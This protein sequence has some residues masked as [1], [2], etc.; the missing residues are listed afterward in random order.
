MKRGF[1][2]QIVVDGE[3]LVIAIICQVAVF[4][5]YNSN[6]THYNAAQIPNLEAR[7]S[8]SNY[9]MPRLFA[10]PRSRIRWIIKAGVSA[11]STTRHV[12]K[13]ETLE[14]YLPVSRLF[15]ST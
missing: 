11:Q 6:N 1:V 12:L 2:E 5:Y 13:A 14:K 15:V 7:L 4:G 9:Q 10:R 8:I 3:R